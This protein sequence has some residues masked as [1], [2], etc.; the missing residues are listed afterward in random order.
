DGAPEGEKPETGAWITTTDTNPIDDSK[1]V[2]AILPAS[3]GESRFGGPVG[4]VVRCKSN[5][6]EMYANW[7]EFLGDDSNSV[8]DEFKLVT[9]RVGDEPAREE[10]WHLSTD[11]Q[12]TFTPGSP[13]PLLK[14]ML[15]A[16]RLVLQTTPYNENPITAVFELEGIQDALA[17]IAETCGWELS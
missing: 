2:T 14:R 6:T 9:V 10:R 11:R 3:Q 1:T 8:Y 5:A 7:H 17:P 15:S 16:E 4:L 12:G 13:I